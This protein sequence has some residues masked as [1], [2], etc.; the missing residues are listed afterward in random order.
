MFYGLLSDGH[1]AQ[2]AACIWSI[3]E[4]DEEGNVI[5]CRQIHNLVTNVGREMLLKDLFMMT[6]STGVVCMGVGASTTAAD[7][8]DT[9]LT[10]ELIDAP[11]AA[12]KPLTNTSGAALSPSDIESG[13]YTGGLLGS[14]T[15]Y[16]RVSCLATWGTADLNG[17]NF[18]EYGLFT[19]PV[20]PATPTSTSG[21]MFNHLID[22]SANFK[23]VTRIVAAQADIYI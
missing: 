4:M 17:N 7:I 20:L 8:T 2:S 21:S 19:T 16:R 10:H 22:S 12:R 14:N 9:R 23:T 5:S 1:E 15:Y 18:G 11:Y 13:T 6:G 3:K